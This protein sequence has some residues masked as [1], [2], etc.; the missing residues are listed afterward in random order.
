MSPACHIYPST[1]GITCLP[2]RPLLSVACLRLTDSTAGVKRD[3]QPSAVLSPHLLSES[4][5][6]LV[7]FLPLRLPAMSPP[8]LSESP[9]CLVAPSFWLPACLVSLSAAGANC[10]PLLPRCPLLLVA[11]LPCLPLFCRNRPRPSA[12]LLSLPFGRLPRV[13]SVVNRQASLGRQR[14]FWLRWSVVGAAHWPPD[15]P[16]SLTRKS[17]RGNVHQ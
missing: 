17:G 2:R 6:F 15:Y 10:R 4:P 14:P 7:A 13:S 1:V 12:A 9:A 5:T 16:S 8:T 3:A 11:C